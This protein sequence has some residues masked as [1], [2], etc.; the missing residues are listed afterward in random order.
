MLR[1]WLIRCTFVALCAV[2]LALWLTSFW[3]GAEIWLGGTTRWSR[4]ILAGGRLVFDS[5]SNESKSFHPWRFDHF[6]A[7]GER[8][9]DHDKVC[10]FRF[11]GFTYYH[12]ANGYDVS[13]PL[14]APTIL[15]GLLL[16]LA[17]RKTKPRSQGAGFPVEFSPA[18][19]EKNS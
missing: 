2:C 8:W 18:I 14:W 5:I 13:I 10:N 16:G 7:E 9:E 4:F 1:R 3:L 6:N 11:L 15:T 19:T 12:G 17:W